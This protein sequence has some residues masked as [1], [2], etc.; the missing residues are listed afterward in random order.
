MNQILLVFST[1]ATAVFGVWLRLQSFAFMPVFGM[2]NGTIAIYSFN[3]G[4]GNISRV[5]KTLRL[6]II[7]GICITA[8][9]SIFYESCPRTLLRLFDAGEN[10]MN[11]GTVAIRSCCISLPFAAVSIILGSSFESLGRPQFSLFGNLFRQIIFLLPLAWLLSRSG[12]LDRIWLAPIFSE[13]A[14]MIVNIFFLRSVF[15]KLT[16]EFPNG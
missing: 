1:T 7:L 4:A 5:K 12:V 2:N 3:Y 10:M 16:R 13:S 6:A 8:A 9:M 15:R 11:I 14:A